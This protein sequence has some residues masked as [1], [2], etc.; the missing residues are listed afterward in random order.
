MKMLVHILLQQLTALFFS[1]LA[2]P[3]FGL[4]ASLIF[5]TLPFPVI[6]TFV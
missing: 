5:S 1:F 3:S 2:S 6:A 4:L